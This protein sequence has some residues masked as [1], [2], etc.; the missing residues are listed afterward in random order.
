M[1][2]IL[3]NYIVHADYYNKEKGGWKEQLI[4]S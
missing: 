4:S 1:I 3:I 2:T